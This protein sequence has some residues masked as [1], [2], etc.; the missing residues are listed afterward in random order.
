[1]RDAAE[2]ARGSRRDR[3]IL[4][5]FFASS[6]LQAT[7]LVV[8]LTSLPFVTRALGSEAY[9]VLATLTGFVALLGFADLGIGAA[10]TTRLALALGRDDEAEA[11][12]VLSTGLAAITAASACLLLGGALLTW[13]LPWNA[14][15][16]VDSLS[17]TAV[18]RAVLCTVAA[19]SLSIFGS[20]GPRVLYG[21]QKGGVANLW[22]L[23]ATLAGA[24][25]SIMAALLKASLF[26]F[27]LT[28]IGSSALVGVACTWWV[29][30]RRAETPPLS[31]EGVGVG[32]FKVLATSSGW[33]FAISVS[34]ILAYQT[35]T[36]IVAHLLGAADAGVFSIA[37]RMYGLVLA[38][39]FPALLQLWPAIGEA[40]SRGDFAWIKSRLKWA[41]IGV[42]VA[43]TLTC[44]AIALFG[45]YGIDR[46]FGRDL[47]PPQALLTTM[48]IF[49]T[50]SLVGAPFALF[51]NAVGRART[52]A[53]FAIAVGIT[54]APL[55]WILTVKIGIAGPVWGSLITNVCLVSVPAAFV[56]RRILRRAPADS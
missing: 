56:V 51:L 38:V 36:L 25:L 8:A 7:A 13:L 55:S 23:V 40:F 50:A 32:E 19:V 16:G 53:Q 49:T 26:V 54:N 31:R 29:L 39:L 12:R 41:T 21:L 24:G 30:L 5:T 10:V 6:G 44:A 20:L 35:D 52:H 22:L 3:S 17:E 33:F 42:S 27:V 14:I 28:G 15:L 9:G 11:S 18:R 2:V 45:R 34:S 43:A 46:L 47:V 37:N 1:M 48:A 4:Q